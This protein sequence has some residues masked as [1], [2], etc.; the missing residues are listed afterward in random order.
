MGIFS[1]RSREYRWAKLYCESHALSVADTA[2]VLRLVK[3]EGFTQ[4]QACNALR[5]RDAAIAKAV[6]D[7]E[8][9]KWSERGVLPRR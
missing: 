3:Q 4:Q 8:D 5:S 2:F 6:A 9:S 1:N 7:Y